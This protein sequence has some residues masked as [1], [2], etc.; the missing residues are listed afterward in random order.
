MSVVFIFHEQSQDTE[1]IFN[2]SCI[3]KS[4]CVVVVNR[5]TNSSWTCMSGL[6]SIPKGDQLIGAGPNICIALCIKLCVINDIGIIE[7]VWKFTF[8]VCPKQWDAIYSTLCNSLNLPTLVDFPNAHISPRENPFYMLRQKLL[9]VFLYPFSS[10]FCE[11]MEHSTMGHNKS[12]FVLDA[13]CELA[14]LVSPCM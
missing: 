5:T 4:A 11:T 7:S 3:F 2:F 9:H 12:V 14:A 6:G 10:Q 13:L 8:W 1:V